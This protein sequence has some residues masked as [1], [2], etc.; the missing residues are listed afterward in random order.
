MAELVQFV[1]PTV[2][3]ERVEIAGDSI[4][5]AIVGGIVLGI[6]KTYF[7]DKIPAYFSLIGGFL[8]LMLYG[9]YPIAKGVGFALVVDGIYSIL[10]QYVTISS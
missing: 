2:N 7:T 10:N 8:L 6:M 3:T 1:Q 4:I 9:N 5:S